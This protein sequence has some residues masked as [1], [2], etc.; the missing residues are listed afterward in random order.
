[1][2]YTYI[3]HVIIEKKP[4]P[5]TFDY[6][7]VMSAVRTGTAVNNHGHQVIQAIWIYSIVRL[8]REKQICLQNRFD[9]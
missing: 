3:D 9:Y 8:K 2:Q 7:Y 5:M 6:A 4:K 1:M